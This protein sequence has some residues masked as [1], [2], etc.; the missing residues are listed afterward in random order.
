[1][2]TGAA[3]MAYTLYDLHRPGAALDYPAG[4]FGAI[5]EAFRTIIEQ[6]GSKVFTSS[7][8]LIFFNF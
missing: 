4:G 3:T 5:G 1:M 8:G 6:T 2:F 7:T